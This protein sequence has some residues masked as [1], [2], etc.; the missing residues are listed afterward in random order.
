[1]TTRGYEVHSGR[2]TVAVRRAATAQEA[3]VEY[4]RG[5]G[6]SLDEIRRMGT[7]TASWR[8]AVYRAVPEETDS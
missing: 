2:R 7:D 3:L 6:C 1:M 4:L 8:G 5:T